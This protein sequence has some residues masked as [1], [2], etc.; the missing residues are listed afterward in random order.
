MLAVSF[1]TVKDINERYTY[2]NQALLIS[3]KDLYKL[4]LEHKEQ[5]N[6]MISKHPYSFDDE[7]VLKGLRQM[8][9]RIIE[10]IR[11]EILS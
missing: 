11:K 3:D 10:E 1:V 4:L 6:N 5:L 2:V 9:R 8:N 7:D